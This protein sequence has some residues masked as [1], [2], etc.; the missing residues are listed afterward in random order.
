[1]IVVGAPAKRQAYLAASFEEWRPSCKTNRVIDSSES[2]CTTHSSSS[3]LTPPLFASI[4]SPTGVIAC[5]WLLREDGPGSTSF[6]FPNSLDRLNFML[7][8]AIF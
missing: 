8:H 6:L 2:R 5:D 1:M 7:F 4:S 3:T